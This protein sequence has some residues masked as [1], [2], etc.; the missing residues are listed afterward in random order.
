MPSSKKNLYLA[1]EV[2]LP[3]GEKAARPGDPLPIRSVGPGVLSELDIS[4]AEIKK[5]PRSVIRAATADEIEAAELREAGQ[6]RQKLL[7]EQAD[8]MAA[9]RAKQADELAGAPADKRAAVEDRQSKAV[10]ALQ[11]KHAKALNAAA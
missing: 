3:T 11:E 9:L 10:T 8:E 4:D 2:H 5:L 6:E 7:A 1:S